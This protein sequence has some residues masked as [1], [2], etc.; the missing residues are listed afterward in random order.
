MVKI[1]NLC[2]DLTS[3]HRIWIKSEW[4]ANNFINITTHDYAVSLDPFLG[5]YT[6]RDMEWTVS[7]RY[8]ALKWHRGMGC[9]TG[10]V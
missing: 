2:L 7:S 9:R 1:K 3:L 8:L 10:Q 4:T 6:R 5:C